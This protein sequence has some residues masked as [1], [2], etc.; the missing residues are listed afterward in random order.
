MLVPHAESLCIG[1]ELAAK[2]NDGASRY[3]GVLNVVDHLV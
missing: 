2:P 3:T 1:I